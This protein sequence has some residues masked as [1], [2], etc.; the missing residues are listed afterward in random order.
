MLILLALGFN[1]SF[2]GGCFAHQP[3]NR[4]IPIPSFSQRIQKFEGDCKKTQE[5]SKANCQEK[6]QWI[7]SFHDA[8]CRMDAWAPPPEWFD[9]SEDKRNYLKK[10]IA[11]VAYEYGLDL[12]NQDNYYKQIF[13]ELPKAAR[14]FLNENPNYV[15]KGKEN[16]EYN[17]RNMLLRIDDEHPTLLIPKCIPSSDERDSLP[18]MVSQSYPAGI[19]LAVIHPKEEPKAK[20]LSPSQIVINGI[21]EKSP[22]EAKKPATLS[23]CQIMINGIDTNKAKETSKVTEESLV[24]PVPD[25]QPVQNITLTLSSVLNS[26]DTL[27]R[28]DYVSTFIFIYPYQKPPN[29][30]IILNDEFWRNF[31]FSQAGRIKGR[32]KNEK[33]LREATDA[34]GMDLRYS[35]DAMRTYFRDVQTTVDIKDLDFGKITRGT[36]DNISGGV[37]ASIPAY[38]ATVSPSLNF[39]SEE[40]TSTETKLLRQLDQHSAYISPDSNFLRITQRG[41]I[42]VNLGGR[43]NEQVQ[44]YVPP[45]AET[46]KTIVPVLETK[47]DKVN[48]KTNFKY[49]FSVKLL[50]QPLYSRVDALVVSLE[51]VRHPTKLRPTKDESFGLPNLDIAD[52]D[53]IVGLPRPS[54]VTLW[55]WERTLDFVLASE[56]VPNFPIQN[57]EKIY[58]D[59]ELSG[60]YDPT[61]LVLTGFSDTLASALRVK[62]SQLILHGEKKQGEKPNTSSD[63]ELFS[64]VEVMYE[65][66]KCSEKDACYILVKDKISGTT[67]RLGLLDDQSQGKLKLKPFNAAFFKPLEK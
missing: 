48:E 60:I 22:N 56:L 63:K 64:N 37:T 11:S 9:Q 57:N 1:L 65:P 26:A 59:S 15:R 18:K 41:M 43:F 54:K 13:Q 20:E 6:D 2:L 46:I 19:S 40:T 28:I 34:I 47:E 27:D 62:I 10:Q 67:I 24:L 51:V 32:G 7:E 21:P 35:F 3:N 50:A 14:Y 58:F 5:P 45:A 16:L 8:L 4:I 42:N 25:F 66:N 36:T 17:S 49:G 30:L 23:G 31:F 33:L 61:P 29:G 55:T 53:F 39:K 44:L 52:T 12:D 38:S